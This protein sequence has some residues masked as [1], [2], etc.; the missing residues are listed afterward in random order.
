MDFAYDEVVEDY[1][2]RLLGFM[3][4]WVFPNEHHFH[5]RPGSD[6]ARWERPDVMAELKAQ[7]RRRGLWNLFLAGHSGGAGLTNLQYAPLAEISG[8][9]PE[10]APEALNCNPPDTGNME[11]LSLFGTD[12]QK[13]EWLTPL[14]AGDMRS[15]YCMTEP[16][17][18]S[19]DASNLRLSIRDDGDSWVL[20]GAKWWSTGAM[21]SDCKLMIVMGVTDAD[22]EPRH[23]HSLILVPTDAPGVDRRRGLEI[24]GFTHS[25]HG[26]HAE[27]RF[28][29]VRVQKSNILGERGR[30]QALAQARLG[31]GRIHHCMRMIGM[32]ERAIQLMCERANDRT[33]FGKTLGEQGIV[34]HWIAQSRVRIAQLRLLVLQAAW[35]IDTVG[36]R[37]ARDAI[38]AIKVA[39]PDTTEWI[40][41]K[42][43]QVFGAEGMTQDHPLAMLWAQART[44]RFIDGADEVHRMVVA[45]R[46]LGRH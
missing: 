13:D 21:S 23:R 35:Q 15:A 36:A 34:Q 19:S 9:S 18:S 27:V 33:A 8:W 32:A 44:M 25:A 42:A 38:S 10:V 31:P 43:I 28:D 5:D 16:G 26:G 12:A 22:A 41:D 1:R 20:D 3:D 39:A 4:E 14:L 29:G 11:L 45:T 6:T 40:I 37:Q 2:E 17:V 7:A 46:E 24:F 30:G